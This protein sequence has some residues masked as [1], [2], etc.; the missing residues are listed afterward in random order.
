M[1]SC[2]FLNCRH[3]DPSRRGCSEGRD[4]ELMVVLHVSEGLSVQAIGLEFDIV[5]QVN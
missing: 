5:E 2:L 1:A 3:V 4:N